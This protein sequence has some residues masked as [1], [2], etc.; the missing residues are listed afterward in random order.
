MTGIRFEKR[1]VRRFRHCVDSTGA[2]TPVWPGPLLP[3]LEPGQHGTAQND[4]RGNRARE[5]TM[6]AGDAVNT[7]READTSV[8]L[9]R[10]FNKKKYTLNDDWKAEYS[11]YIN[12]YCYWYRVL[13]AAHNCACH[14][15]QS[16]CYTSSM[17]TNRWAMAATASLGGGHFSAPV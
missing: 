4:V 8:A 16:L 12:Q 3:G 7:R 14:T 11:K 2:H 6:Q 9:R 10:F 1:V 15:A 5:K 13:R 17:A